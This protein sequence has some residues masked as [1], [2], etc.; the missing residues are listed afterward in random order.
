MFNNQAAHLKGLL[1]GILLLTLAGCAGLSLPPSL[2]ADVS[3]TSQAATATLTVEPLPMSTET[4]NPT[5]TPT[6]PLPSPSPSPVPAPDL[7]V[8][9]GKMENLIFELEGYAPRKE[10]MGFVQPDETA[11][12][13]FEDVVDRLFEGDAA[14]AAELAAKYDYDL[15]IYHTWDENDPA[16]YLL[17]ERIPIRRGWGMY[18]FQLDAC[19]NS[20]QAIISQ[21]P[22][23]LADIGTPMIAMEAFRSLKGCALMIGGA[24]RDANRDDSA[25]IAHNPLT[26]YLAVQTALVRHVGQAAYIIQ[27]HGFSAGKHPGYP[28]IVLGAYQF[29][30][31]TSNDQLVQ[32]A[33]V[34]NTYGI[35][36]SICDGSNWTALCGETNVLG[37][38]LNEGTFVHVEMDEMAR[39][40][41][42]PLI[43]NLV[44]IYK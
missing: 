36:T 20:S 37:G 13:D 34:L 2:E 39:S 44:E 41:P 19:Q 33:D 18:L 15:V 29:E 5:A 42:V 8:Y 28:S 3:P 6:E 38:Y 25:D 35:S 9:T 30:D 1:F 16:Y 22:H 7:P 12:R 10:S 43:Q 21:A 31:A 27:F 24:H 32:L 17:R 40:N 23:I 11:L 26:V 14:G 4:P